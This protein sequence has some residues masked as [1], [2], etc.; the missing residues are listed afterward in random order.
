MPTIIRRALAAVAGLG[1][2]ALGGAAIAGA[3]GG[4]SSSSNPT[5]STP[6]PPPAHGEGGSSSG[7][8]PDSGGPGWSSADAPGTPAHE[9][10]EKAVTGE[11]AAKA[12][13]AAL[14]SVPGKAGDVTTDF[15]GTGYE[16]TVTKSD[17]SEVTV[18]LDSAFK[19]MAM[20]HGGPGWP[21]GPGG[22]AGAP[23]A[24]GRAPS[25]AGPAYGQAPPAA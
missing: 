7:P 1:A 2:L 13:S 22:A 16:V 15:R 5:T 24:G 17:G 4:G 21:G 8:R 11:A 25:G 9:N 14:A 20:P 18:H 6:A 10:A 3:A 12:K 19:V 23:P